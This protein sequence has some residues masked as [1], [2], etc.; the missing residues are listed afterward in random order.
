ME[1]KEILNSYELTKFNNTISIKSKHFMFTYIPP[2][3]IV[4]EEYKDQYRY[5]GGM[6]CNYEEDTEEYKQLEQWLCEIAEKILY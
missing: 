4:K 5:F 3:D 2:N 6:Q 1:K